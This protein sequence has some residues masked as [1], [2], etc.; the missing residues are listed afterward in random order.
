MHQN[1]QRDDILLASAR[2]R[3]LDRLRVATDAPDPLDVLVVGQWHWEEKVTEEV[4]PSTIRQAV[5]MT[6]EEEGHARKGF[7]GI[8][9][10]HGPHWGYGAGGMGAAIAVIEAL[11]RLIRG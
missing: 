6:L 3:C 4:I 1:G 2:Q 8:L 7:K 11:T 5:H 10:D 9:R